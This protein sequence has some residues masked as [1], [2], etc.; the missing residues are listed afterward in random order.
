[1]FG[2][3]SDTKATVMDIKRELDAQWA[4]PGKVR[5]IM[6]RYAKTG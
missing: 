4:C 5:V 6:I 1:M 3:Y 2:D